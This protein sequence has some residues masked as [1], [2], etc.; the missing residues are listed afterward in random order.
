LILFIGEKQME[1]AVS[2]CPNLDFS[3]VPSSFPLLAQ[4][5]DSAGDAILIVDAE[6]RIVWANR[7]FARMSGFHQ[8]EAVG[9]N[10]AALH[11]QTQAG[12]SY[13][14]LRQ[15]EVSRKGVWQRELIRKRRDGSI[16]ITEEIV[17]PLLDQAGAITHFVTVLRD[18]TQSRAA[19]QQERLQARQDTLTGLAGRAQIL[20]LLSSAV[21]AA[22]QSKQILAVLFIDL[23]GFKQINDSAG[24]HI[25]DAVLRA[26]AARLQGAV[27]CTDTVA[28]F[29]GDEFL[30]LLPTM[31]GRAVGKRIGRTIVQQLAQPFAI[32]PERHALSASVGAAFHPEHGQTPEALLIS[33]DAAMYRSKRNGGSQFRIAD[34]SAVPIREMPF[35]QGEAIV[36]S[37]NYETRAS[38]ASHPGICIDG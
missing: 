5:I 33:A 8:E 22:Q 28:R 7:A 34:P 2:R 4:A 17:T 15:S 1:P 18:V 10:I 16:Y 35:R 23:D 13:K 31:S 25:G 3:R 32:G 27:R 37:S 12:D 19:I 20:E 24:H 30:V 36:E 26:V 9:A 6:D 38:A 21:F 11:C 29:G 14:S